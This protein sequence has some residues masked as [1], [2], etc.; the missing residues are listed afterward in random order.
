MAFVSSSSSHS[1]G[2]RRPIVKA[3]FVAS[4]L[5]SIV[6]FYTTQQGMALYLNGWFSFLAALGV[7]LALVLVAWLIGFSKGGRALLV[8]VYVITAIVSIGFSYVT[9]YTRFSARERPAQVERALYDRLGAAAAQTESVLTSAITEG[10]K[11]ALALE[12]M[13][14]AEREH[15]FISKA[16]DSDLYLASVRESVGREAQTYTG[17][18][19][20]GAGLG[21][22]Y[23]A[24]E[25]YA[26]I[27]RQSVTQMEQAQ[28]GLA[29]LRAQAK[30]LDP[31]EKQLR[32]FHQVYDSIPWNDVEQ[33]L[34]QGK[35]ERPAV[36][37][38]ADFVDQ[39]VSGQE[40][41]MLAF[42]EL[43]SAPTSRHIFSFTLATFIDVIVFLLAYASGPY[44][45]GSPEQRWC[46][47]GAVLD[48]T[49]DQL[50]LRD[51]L[52]KVESG[53]RGLPRVEASRLTAG[54]LQFCLQLVAKNTAT[55]VDD[56]R[57]YYVLDPTVHETLLDALKTRDLPLRADTQRA[58]AGA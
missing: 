1:D 25:R 7:Q 33:T 55:T 15:G 57:L 2:V 46:A 42:T 40:D 49:G 31:T 16:P 51:L 54:E 56:G 36:P 44:F 4:C 5:L 9:L 29:G 18:V 41:L 13:T 28:R 10:R 37:A 30:P 19:R 35:V 32:S 12:E 21:P 17:A 50:F 8:T 58:P 34:H 27:A 53:P 11:H 47:A 22:R 48:A 39:S 43:F 20:E 6:S 38:Y 3:L 52:R 26:K 14:G 24:F 23:T 45:F